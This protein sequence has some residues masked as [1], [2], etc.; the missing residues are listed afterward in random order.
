MQIIPR[1]LSMKQAAQYI[2]MPLST[3]KKKYMDWVN[4]LNPSKVGSNRLRFDR[5]KIDSLMQKLRVIRT[6]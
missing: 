6:L 5:E 3:F 2:D 4:D 1:Y